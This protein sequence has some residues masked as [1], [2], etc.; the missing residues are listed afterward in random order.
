[1]RAIAA[2]PTRPGTVYVAEPIDVKD[3]AGNL[4]DHADIRFSRSDDFGVTW[5]S[6]IVTINDDN[7]GVP[8]DGS[9]DD[10]SADQ[11]MVQLSVG[12]DGS[13]GLVWLDTRRDPANKMLDV[14]GAVSTD[15]GLSFSPNFRITDQSFDP[16]QGALLTSSGE[17]YL[18]DSIG[19]AMAGSTMYTAWTDT[20]QGNQDIYFRRVSL[21]QLPA[22]LND[23]FEPNDAPSSA[24]QLGPVAA[25]R[26]LPKL[27]LTPGDEDWFELQAL[28]SAKLT[29][30][31]NSS[32]PAG[33][34]LELY[35]S[36][37]AQL[38]A[39]GVLTAGVKSIAYNVNAGSTYLVRVA[40]DNG[41][42]F[43]VKS[44]SYSLSVTN[45]TQDL[46]TIAHA[47]V[48][49]ATL[50]PGEQ[51]YYLLKST[52][53]GSIS[54]NLTTATGFQGQ[55]TIELL[56]PTTLAVL[57]SDSGSA[58]HV[59]LP[60]GQGTP[61]L[62]H[63]TAGGS[64]QGTY[65]LDLVN[66]DQF[67]DP[68]LDVL[69]YSA[70]ADPSQEA[71]ADFNRDGNLDVAIANAGSN[72]V[73]ILLGNHNGTF[74]APQQFAIRAFHLP[75]PAGNLFN[76]GTFR[77]DILTAD[78]NEDGVPDLVVTNYDS[79][80]V[81]VLL[82]NG[83]GTFQP[84]R[85]FDAT[86]A[87]YGMT[88]GDVNGDQHLDLLVA[89]T[90]AAGNTSLAVLLGRGDGTFEPETLQSLRHFLAPPTL[91]LADLDGNG[92]LDLIAAGGSNPGL[93]IYSGDGQGGFVLTAH[94]SGSREATD[95]IYTDV[96]GDHIPDVLATSFER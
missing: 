70:G 69:R 9:V 66:L 14:F 56:D 95:V 15:G 24:T 42:G 21:S 63:V 68:D 93:D 92:T 2:D 29:V 44:A 36:S 3:S 75:N 12:A 94:Y 73:S 89:D 49:N 55:A 45:L 78:F 96:D 54:A 52:A 5:T 11:I 61:L 40:A 74:S 51:S 34:K 32:L 8:A 39:S 62:V 7:G 30:T 72:T 27:A 28:A 16:T 76:L 37:G 71:V 1:M 33:T 46:G 82:G 81:S 91:T 53:A 86:A 18:G 85:R 58:P 10:V 6:S 57:A 64:G 50:L 83:D 79:S 59:K 17:T 77:R 26:I 4:L 87:P 20:R 19:L 43:T 25:P 48:A 35:D 13:I 84:Q 67:S 23:R 90:Y 88:F 41:G 22:S 80:D 38:L 65:S 47:N 31:V 60:V